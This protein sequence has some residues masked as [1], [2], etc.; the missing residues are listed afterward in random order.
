MRPPFL[1]LY[2]IIC[3]VFFLQGSSRTAEA[4]GKRRISNQRQS[5]TLKLNIFP[6]TV[7]LY[8]CLCVVHNPYHCQLL[9]DECLH[10]ASKKRGTTQSCYPDEGFLENTSHSVKWHPAQLRNRELFLT[11]KFGCE[12]RDCLEF[13]FVMVC[14][15]MLS[16][17][18]DG[19]G[20]A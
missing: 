20:L 3:F 18:V 4:A 14:K 13:T 8:Y 17:E 19:T 12:G 9:W 11:D 10:L 6:S 15:V 2:M 16:L 5:E 7:M 1:V